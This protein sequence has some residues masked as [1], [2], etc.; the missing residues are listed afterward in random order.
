M[1]R[2]LPRAPEGG[3]TLDHVRAARERAVAPAGPAGCGRPPSPRSIV[4]EPDRFRLDAGPGSLHVARIG[5]GARAVVLVHGFGTTHAVWR[6]IAPALVRAR[7]TVWTPDLLGFGES[8]RPIEAPLDAAAQAGYLRDALA[9]GSVPRATFVGLDLGALVVLVLAA[10]AP[11][12]VE[13][14]V[15]VSPLVPASLPPDDVAALQRETGAH[16]LRLARDVAGAAELIGPLL[17]SRAADPALISDALVARYTAPF[18]GRH[19]VRQL[20]ALAR[21]L[22]RANAPQLTPEAVR[23]PALVVRGAAEP[24]I[25]DDPVEHFVRGL[26]G[27]RS[28][29]LEGVGRLAPEEAPAA[30]AA[31]IV[32]F[33]AG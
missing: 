16:A 1:I 9:A 12:L 21:S 27:A 2:T 6:G 5:H 13:R 24:L 25:A 32:A 23:V 26:A 33:L 22:D 14:A 18:V 30:L 20:L 8:D 4:V 19:G 28:L 15:L 29:R 31:V 3:K 10:V 11:Q 17:R 7:C